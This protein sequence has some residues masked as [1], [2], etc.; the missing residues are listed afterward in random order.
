MKLALVTE[1]FPPEINGVAMTFGMIARELGRRGH[2]VSVY[3]PRRDDLPAGD[4]HPEF[5][6]V[7]MPGFPIPRYPMLR[8]GLPAG[9]ALRRMWTEERPDLVHVATEGPLGASAVSAARAMGIPVTS[10]FHTN[11]HAYTRHYGFG[12][13]HRSVLAWLRH[14]HNRTRRTFAPT[15]ELCHELAA[16]GFRETAL[17]SRGVDTWQFH[18]ARRAGTL[19]LKW[20]ADTND[21]VVIH[22]GRMA[23]EKN[24]GLLVR[25]FA[26]MRAANP[27]CRFVLVGDGPLRARLQRE[28]RDFVFPGFVPRAELA[29]HY[30]SADIYIHASLTETFGNVL[31]EAMASGLAVAGF[32]YAAARQ[33]V[34]HGKN[35]LA[36]PCAAPEALVEAAVLLVTDDLLRA[37]LRGAARLAVESQSWETVIARF[38][39]DLAAVA[40]EGVVR[41]EPVIA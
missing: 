39:A 33:F 38:E 27:R 16:L 21:P 5:A 10:S 29:R 17:L 36:V 26:A 2:T 31:T 34:V 37:Q 9:R 28:H 40:G 24:Y 8:M 41:P 30:A 12:L 35:G 14:V 13:F 7:P 32:D 4:P 18:P 11:F 23:A 6:E 3:R 22:A 25:A 19:R 15:V 1:T 20:G